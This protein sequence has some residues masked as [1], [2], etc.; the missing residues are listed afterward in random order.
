MESYLDRIIPGIFL[1]VAA[2]IVVFIIVFIISL[3][4][5]II[6]LPASTIGFWAGVLVFF[7]HVATGYNPFSKNR[8]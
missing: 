8:A 1:G 4:T 7:L 3:L 2:G 5:P 6:S